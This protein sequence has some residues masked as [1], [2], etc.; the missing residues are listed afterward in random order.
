[1]SNEYKDW[2]RDQQEEIA[3]YIPETWY[4]EE[5]LPERVRLLVEAWEEVTNTLDTLENDPE[6]LEEFYLEHI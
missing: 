3:G 5:T 2:M 4:P 1:M 6:A